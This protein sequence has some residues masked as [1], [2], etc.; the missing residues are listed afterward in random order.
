MV[1]R[2]TAV[3]VT[4]KEF[5]LALLLFQHLSRP[6]SRAHILDVI[7]KQATEIPSR[8]MDTHVSMLR[9][10]LGLAARKRLSP[11]A[12]LRLWIPAGAHRKGGCVSVV[13]IHVAGMSAGGAAPRRCGWRCSCRALPCC[14]RGAR[15]RARAAPTRTSSAQQR[16]RHH[17]SYTTAAGDTL[18]EI[19]ARY[20]RDPHDWAVLSRLNKVPAPRHLQAGIHAATAGRAAAAGSRIGAGDGDERSGRARVRHRTLH[21]ARGGHDARRRR[22]RAHRP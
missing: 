21:A 19:A 5:D 10:K 22:S 11:D 6:L 9:S 18:Y 14:L 12:D 16:R 7:W 4:Q 13:R 17:V 15:A 20:L 1:V 3:A 8:T 2:G